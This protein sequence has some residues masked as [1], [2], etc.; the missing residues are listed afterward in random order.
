MTSTSLVEETSE[1]LGQIEKYKIKFA[2]AVFIKQMAEYKLPLAIC[3]YDF[4]NGQKHLTCTG[5]SLYEEFLPPV[6]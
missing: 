6:S 3:L 5:V 2:K 1:D 4:F